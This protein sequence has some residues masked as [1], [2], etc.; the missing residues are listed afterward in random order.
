MRN[1]RKGEIATLLTLGLVVVGAVI[2]LATS[3][4]TN[5]QKSIA[6]N[7]K[8]A[9]VNCV[10]STT[11]LCTGECGSTCSS[12]QKC[13][14]GKYRCPGTSDDS[15]TGP[16]SPS[17][18]SP[19]PIKSPTPVA[20]SGGSCNS[21]TD[22]KSGDA[23]KLTC[24][25]ICGSYANY[26][27]GGKKQ[28]VEGNTRYC[29]CGQ[30]FLPEGE[31][32]SCW[33][34][35]CELGKPQM[36]PYVDSLSAHGMPLSSCQGGSPYSGGGWRVIGTDN[37]NAELDKLV[38]DGNVETTKTPTP[39]KMPTNIPTLTKTPSKTPS[40]TKTPNAGSLNGNCRNL[41][42]EQNHYTGQCDGS[43]VCDP[44]TGKCK[45]S[46]SS[47]P[48][49]TNAPL[50]NGYVDVNSCTQ[51]SCPSNKTGTYW[52]RNKKTGMQITREYLRDEK[53]CRNS[54]I[55]GVSYTA[56]TNDPL[57]CRANT[58]LVLTTPNFVPT[59]TP[60]Q[61]QPFSM[62]INSQSTT[63]GSTTF[64]IDS[65]CIPIVDGFDMD[66]FLGAVGSGSLNV[67][68]EAPYS[69]LI[70]RPSLSGPP[71]ITAECCK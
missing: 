68:C 36:L 14:N 34:I 69:K 42:W 59:V 67:K 71:F 28:W 57:V 8:A 29:C 40:P 41:N 33:I 11:N 50:P 35:K 70:I 56:I 45:Q 6:S 37:A 30:A 13:T 38:C 49:L 25:N 17:T 44:T 5:N 66:S 55:S 61:A 18:N 48:T 22:K 4:L 64:E 27:A 1:N 26:E 24:E 43:L 31:D 3:I 9:T 32:D 65:Q 16:T 54:S 21:S 51:Y 39:T 53:S 7:P 52:G 60:V 15:S 58:P 12:S 10:Y 2:T 23:S 19:T 20:G 63:A 62:V 46:G 47:I